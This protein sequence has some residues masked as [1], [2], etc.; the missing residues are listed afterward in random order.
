MKKVLL[1]WIVLAALVL[2]GVIVYGVVS[3]GPVVK[4]A[5]EYVGPRL[6]GAPVSLDEAEV[7]LFSGEGELRGLFVG[8]PPGFDSPM[9]LEAAS[10]SLS[11]D[12]SSFA[13]DVLVVRS[14]SLSG[15]RLTYERSG[16]GSNL[17]TLLA[18]ARRAAGSEDKAHAARQGD[19]GEPGGEQKLIIDDFRITD[20]SLALAVSGMSGPLATVPLPDIHLSG[21]GRE[22]G[23]VP[24]SRVVEAVLGAVARG[25]AQAVGS[26][27]GSAAEALSRGAKAVRGALEEGLRDMLGQ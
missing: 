10:L 12:R 15:P 13:S 26:Q 4:K 17:E 8:N 1:T 2:G 7:S 22:E 24:P 6:L 25:A 9:A 27:A 18:N 21:I 5:V 16:S 19:G 11:V 23:G 20:A 3:V 14:L